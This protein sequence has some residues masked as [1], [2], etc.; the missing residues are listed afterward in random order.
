MHGVERLRPTLR[1][2]KNS[3]AP[4]FR[5]KG[6]GD[7]APAELLAAAPL[8][9]EELGIRIDKV[10]DREL[11]KW[12]IASL[13][14][15]A[16]VT[17]CIAKQGYLALKRNRLLTPQH[18]LKAGAQRIRDTL[19]QAGYVRAAREKSTAIVGACQ[20]LL[21]VYHGS[22]QR[23]HEAAENPRELETLLTKFPGVGPVTANIFLRELRPFWEKANP[24]PLDRIVA[25][26]RRIGLDPGAF[27]RK[28]VEFSRLEAGLVRDLARPGEMRKLKRR[29]PISP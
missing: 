18:I 8:Y 19:A 1:L 20:R 4:K 14:F 25:H 11:F 29:R 13:L 23:L 7:K 22:L 16:R 2:S 6:C 21:A 24:A 17:P 9:S 10:S 27:P 5:D 28:S 12:F 15:G 3:S 26:A